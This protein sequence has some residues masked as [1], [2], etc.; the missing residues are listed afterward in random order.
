MELRDGVTYFP[1]KTVLYSTA[2]AFSAVAFSQ[3]ETKLAVG[4][5]STTGDF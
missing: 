5:T 3:D 4:F 2:S 1:Y